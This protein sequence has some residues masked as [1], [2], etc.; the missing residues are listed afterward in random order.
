MIAKERAIMPCGCAAYVGLRMDTHDPTLGA[1][2]CCHEHRGK[3][4][5]FLAAYHESLERPSDRDA[6]EVADELL[7][8]VF[9]GE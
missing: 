2:A 7:T 6:V 5:A 1:T 4:H 3:V 9:A 8:R